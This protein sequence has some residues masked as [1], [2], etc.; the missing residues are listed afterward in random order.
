MSKEDDIP[1][2]DDPAQMAASV[3]QD[4]TDEPLDLEGFLLQL[5][6][7]NNGKGVRLNHWKVVMCCAKCKS[8]LIY[9]IVYLA[10]L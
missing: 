5:M 1:E 2:S 10:T 6:E 3:E 7:K 9:H 8:F 4:K